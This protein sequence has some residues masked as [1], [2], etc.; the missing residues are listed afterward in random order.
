MNNDEWWAYFTSPDR[1]DKHRREFNDWE[2]AA[3]QPKGPAKYMIGDVI[4]FEAGGVGV[5]GKSEEEANGWPVKYSVAKI[6]NHP[7]HP[8]NIMA[9]HYEG[10]IKRLLSPSG[11]RSFS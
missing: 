6:P 1:R 4:E 9:W 8:R 2:W 11:L 3:A 5:V 7:F 10:D